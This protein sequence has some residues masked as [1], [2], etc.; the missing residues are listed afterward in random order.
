MKE[1]KAYVR[2]NMRDAVM[3][4]LAAIPGLPGIAVVHLREYGHAADDG[5]LAKAG[6]AK[7]ELDVPD[8][9][10]EPVVDTILRHARTGDG[11]AGDGKIFVSN[12]GE[13]VRISD[14]ARG[15]AAVTRR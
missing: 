9:L 12:L 1:I 14:G 13:A 5:G 7:L 6:M 4:A 10:A 8:A 11:H 15:E 3:D 2:E